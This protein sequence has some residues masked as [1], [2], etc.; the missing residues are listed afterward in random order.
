MK[1]SLIVSLLLASVLQVVVTP[2]AIAEPFTISKNGQ[3][4]IDRETGLVWRRCAEGMLW[5]GSSCEGLAQNF[6]HVEA[7]FRAK[8]VAAVTGNAWRLP[9]LHELLSIANPL[10]A[11]PAID[12]NAFPATPAKKFWSSSLFVRENRGDALNADNAMFVHFGKG[13]YL[14][15]DR[16]EVHHVRLVRDGL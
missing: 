6:S 7:Q 10:L 5:N 12:A 3:E 1:T 4:V 8:A 11:A 9:N 2:A 14:Y 16:A 15:A 13:G